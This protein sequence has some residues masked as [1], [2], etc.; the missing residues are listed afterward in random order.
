MPIVWAQTLSCCRSTRQRLD[1]HTFFRW[2]F[3]STGIKRPQPLPNGCRSHLQCVCQQLS[4]TEKIYGF[5]K[6]LEV[7]F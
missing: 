5:K 1:Q 7:R 6:F 2:D 4:A 3:P